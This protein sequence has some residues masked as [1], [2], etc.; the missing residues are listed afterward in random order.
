MTSLYRHSPRAGKSRGYGRQ[1]KL[2]LGTIQRIDTRW[3][4]VKASAYLMKPWVF[5]D[6]G[7]ALKFLG[8]KEVKNAG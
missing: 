1:L 3:Y 4:V 5:D 2:R 7:S 8:Y 6:L